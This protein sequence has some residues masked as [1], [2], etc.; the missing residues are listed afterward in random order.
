MDIFGA[1]GLLGGLSLFL[2]GM[3]VMGTGLEIVS[4]GKLESTL[5]RLTDNKL[6]AVGLGLIVTAIIQSSSATTVMVVGFVNSGIMKLSQSVGVIMGANIGTTVT[7][8][9][10]SLTGLQGDNIFIKLL[11]P[12]SFTPILA[13]IGII[14]LSFCKKGKRK[15]IGSIL[16]GFSVLM[17]GMTM[18]SDAVA[19]LADNP[20]FAKV[21]VMFSNPILGVLAGAVLTA[22]IQSSSASVGILQ[23][24]CA[25]GNITYGTA[26]PIIM[27]QNIG[28]CITALLSCIGANKNA[29][30]AAIIHLYIN[31][32]GSILFL[33]LFYSL[34]A[35][36]DFSF[37]RNA[38][39][40]KDIAV[41]HTL[42]NLFATAILLPF[43]NLLCKL[44][45][46]TVRSK[47]TV[48]ETPILDERFLNTP[49]FALTQCKN[50][51]EKMAD[52]SHSA[53]TKSLDMLYHYSDEAAAEINHLES[54]VDTYEDA[55][56]TY[57]VKISEKSI[58]QEDSR[59]ISKL[60]HVIG[61]FER[62]S[63][64]AVNLVRTSKEIFDKKI[65]FSK[66]AEAGLSVITD[67]LKE[68]L[69]I[70][71]DAFA[72]NDIAEAGRVE[73][74]EQVIDGLK[75]GLKNQ[76]IQRLQDGDCTIELGFVFSDI[77][78]NFERI[79]DHCS[80]IAVC[81]IQIDQAALDTHEYLNEVK[82][83]D[84]E[85]IAEFEDYKE[86]YK[87]PSVQ[88]AAKD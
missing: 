10:L 42:F 58:S 69:S 34:N 63:D 83:G 22:I 79:S 73:P 19:P 44:A 7:A 67:A 12:T 29:K 18:M 25:T 3:H 49:S 9:L 64:H 39:N 40:A 24:L 46:L 1:L 8:W 77:L 11:K 65:H 62:I 43:S 84:P 54:L 13:V 35:I 17:F 16:I 41:V 59:E 74:L 75:A 37:I 88:A 30:R 28:T 57:L 21:L 66:D 85:F 60:L 20:H 78:T 26:I 81:I 52:L 82:S 45:T 70:T 27:G 56:G 5:E 53:L 33:S 36:F 80:N 55:L 50:A 32:I 31:I 76:H 51:A 38:M 61:D 23:A 47:D 87:L 4:G 48:Q 68:I 14:M 6:K 72:K 2:Y 15:D 71:V 86:K